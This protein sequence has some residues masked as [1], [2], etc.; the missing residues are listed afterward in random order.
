TTRIRL[1]E[2]CLALLLGR[3][4]A[5]ESL[6]LDPFTAVVVE[7]DGAIEQV[8]SLKS[9][10]EGAAATGLDVF[11]HSFDTALAHPGVRARQAGA[12]ALA[13]ECRACP[14]LTVC[15]GGHYAHRYR[16]GDGFAHPSVYCADLKKFIRHVAVALD[17]AARGAPGEPR[18]APV[19][20]ASR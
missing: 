19:P 12:A 20:G 8:D 6:G 18:P 13:A 7:T 17:R 15:G 2:E 9:A 3:P 10:Y 5:T 1:F 14:L 16:A 4:A 11:A